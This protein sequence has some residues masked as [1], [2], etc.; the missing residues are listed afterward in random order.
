FPL[1]IQEMVEPFKLMILFCD[2][3]LLKTP[4]HIKLP[5]K[6][7][8]AMSYFHRNQAP[9]KSTFRAE[10]LCKTL[11]MIGEFKPMMKR[12]HSH[13]AELL[14]EPS[15]NPNQKCERSCNPTLPA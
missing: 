9:Q 7:K 3:L 1:F 15:A 4:K 2:S 11:P 8:M 12:E 14:S 10:H 13:G 5:L 6:M